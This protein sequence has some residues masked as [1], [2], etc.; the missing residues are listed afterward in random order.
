LQGKVF[1]PSEQEKVLLVVEVDQFAKANEKEEFEHTLEAV[2]SLAV[3]LT[4]QGYAVGL[5]TNGAIIGEGPG[6]IPV[7]RNQEQLPAILEVL[8]RL[9]MES[10]G[11]LLEA[12]QHGFDLP[13]GL[14]CVLFLFEED[15]T[16]FVIRKYF[17]HR[18]IPITFLVCRPSPPSRDWESK[19]RSM[20]RG[21]NDIASPFPFR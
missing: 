7:A 12:M 17:E 10:S 15:K 14:S 20:V 5:T 21:L 16:T 8:A 3:R 11:G 4:G 18:R 9:Q 6:M 13:W 1:E 19:I 2:A